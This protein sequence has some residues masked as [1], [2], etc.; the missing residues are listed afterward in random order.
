MSGTPAGTDPPEG[1]GLQLAFRKCGGPQV[2]REGNCSEEIR[3]TGLFVR[4][5]ACHPFQFPICLRD[6]CCVSLLS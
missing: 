2:R 4:Q 6:I 1:R 5:A 3:A